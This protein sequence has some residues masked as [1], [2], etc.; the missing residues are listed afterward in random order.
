M[1]SLF[2]KEIGQF[3]KKLANY[4]KVRKFKLLDKPFSIETGEIT[5]SLKVKRKIIEE[6]F[7]HLIEKMYESLGRN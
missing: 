1:K 6:K 3:Q 7:Q 4:E 5:P 2:D